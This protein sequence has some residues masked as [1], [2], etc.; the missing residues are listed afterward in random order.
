MKLLSRF[1][2]SKE[3]KKVGKNPECG[4]VIAETK[5]PIRIGEGIDK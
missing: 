3:E 5:E 2:T 1:L 4:K